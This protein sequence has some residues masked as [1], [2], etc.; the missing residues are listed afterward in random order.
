MSSSPLPRY[1]P[2][3]AEHGG[4]HLGQHVWERGPE[5][6]GDH[7]VHFGGGG[8]GLHHADGAEE[9]EEGAEAEE[10]QRSVTFTHW[11][12]GVEMSCH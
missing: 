7:H 2:P 11:T 5:N 10:T 1:N 6:G 12:W 9:E 8:A 3:T 4:P